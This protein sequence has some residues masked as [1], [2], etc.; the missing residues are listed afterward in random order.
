MAF[1]VQFPL[2]INSETGKYSLND[3]ATLQSR[4][5]EVFPAAVRKAILD[6]KVQE[7]SCRD[8]G[9]AYG[10]GDAW[11]N[12]AK[13]GFAIES[14]NIGTPTA[15]R[16]SNQRMEFACQTDKYRIVVDSDAS[17]IPR[18]R[19][20]NRPHPLTDNPDLEIAKGESGVDGTGLCAY[21]VWTFRSGKA[22]YRIEG[23]LGCLGDTEAPKEAKGGFQVEIEGHSKARGWCY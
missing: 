3:P 20:W 21:P 11:V 18:Y 22:T 15:H 17:R 9:I 12:V 5:Q 10:N 2:R 7:I 23:A 4:F 14:I 13:F 6:Q 19:A 8:E 1:L 16:A